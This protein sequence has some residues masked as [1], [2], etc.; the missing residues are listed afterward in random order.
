MTDTTTGTGTVIAGSAKEKL[1]SCVERIERLEEERATLA[2]DIKDIMDQAKSEGFDSKVIK[3]VLKL[4]KM[5][6][7]DRR[8]HDAVLTTYLHALGMIEEDAA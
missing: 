3:E 5:D 2:G 8:D 7:A 6:P 1:R 4:R